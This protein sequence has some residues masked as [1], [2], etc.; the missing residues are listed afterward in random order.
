MLVFF[1]CFDSVVWEVG[2]IS[3]H[4]MH[5]VL[6]SHDSVPE[7]VEQKARLTNQF[8]VENGT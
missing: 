3:G 6:I 1:H 7:L 5:V 8:Y 4:I 2:T